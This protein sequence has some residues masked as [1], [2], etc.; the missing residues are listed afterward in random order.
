MSARLGRGFLCTLRGRTHFFADCYRVT[1]KD[2]AQICITGLDRPVVFRGQKYRPAGGASKSQET[3]GAALET[4]DM[5]VSGIL[6]ADFIQGSD[7]LAGLYT[8]AE[9]EHWVVDWRWPYKHYLK[10]VW[11][12]DE[13]NRDG[14][15]WVAR[16]RPSVGRAME[17]PVGRKFEI[18]CDYVFGDP[19][20]CK[21]D[22]TALTLA[23]VAVETIVED[24]RTLRASAATLTGTWNDDDF[25]NG[26]V[27]WT[28]GNNKGVTSRVQWS[29]ASSREL[30]LFD[31]TP[32]KF[33]A[34]DTFTLRA[35]CGGTLT[36]CLRHDNVLNHGQNPYQT[37]PK[38]TYLQDT[39]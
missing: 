2:K 37:G 34:G 22:L 15:Q 27:V 38:E 1:R 31:P 4:G 25:R 24:Y 12:V 13:M 5:E 23:G 17:T 3:V 6:T 21:K 39:P 29:I 32:F 11:V 18:D 9:I 28:S 33:V 20:T 26:E 16:V 36:D 35:G 7:I 30:G 10:A 14:A 8:D 19:E